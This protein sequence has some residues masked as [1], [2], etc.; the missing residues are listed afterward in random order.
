MAKQR[1]GGKNK[2]N[3]RNCEAGIAL[4]PSEAEQRSSLSSEGHVLQKSVTMFF[5][6]NQKGNL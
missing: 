1:E 2:K 4:F 6:E 3:Y 5:V